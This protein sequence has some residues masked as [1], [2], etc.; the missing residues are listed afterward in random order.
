M[1]A[2]YSLATPD[3]PGSAASRDPYRDVVLSLLGAALV[4]MFA[5]AYGGLTLGNPALIDAA[6][7]L[8]LA[9]G[10]LACVALTQLVRA[11]P[12]AGVDAPPEMV[13]QETVRAAATDS[14]VAS[15]AAGPTDAQSSE[16]PFRAGLRDI[17]APRPS[18]V[19]AVRI[20]TAS[21]ALGAIALLLLGD[22][23]GTPALGTALVAGALC[24]VAAGL[25]AAVV[26]YL[27]GIDAAR[28]PEAEALA[29]GARV[30][31]WILTLTAVAVLAAWAGQTRAVL[32]LHFIVLSLNAA[33]CYSLI[34][35]SRDESAIVPQLSLN[36]GVLTTFGSRANALGSMLD[37]GERQLGIDLR[38]TWA[39]TVVRTGL[40]PLV[41]GLGLLGWLSTSLTVV[42]VQEQGLI[43]RLGIAVGGDPLGPGLHVHWPWPI[44]RVDRLPMNL[45][46]RLSIG[47][48]GEEAEGPE[49]VL[50]ARQHAENEFT[51][52][53]GNGRDLITVDAALQFR[54]ADARAWRYHTQN[55]ADALRA[56]AYRAV[57]RNTVNRTLTDALSENVV[58]TTARMR[59]M[60]QHDADALGLGV[61]VLGFTVAGMHPPVPVAD[62]YEAVVSAELGRVTAAVRAQAERNQLLPQAESAVL[63]G[64]N[65]ARAE[66]ATALGQAAGDA[67][68]FLAIQSEYR[69]SS[70]E[71]FFRQRL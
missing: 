55:P 39:L 5:A 65:S 63:V 58:A 30:L 32:L 1:S 45:V 71:F 56:I 23:T 31:A 24:I 25:V 47:H 11:R 8:E 60:V 51:L 2:S 48:E 64:E 17:M 28:L 46:Q 40:E 50:W 26:R 67:S 15:P 20:V 7:S 6:V 3:R 43:E 27:I 38:S 19:H 53:L 49:D 42:G 70:V 18:L 33:V 29:R 68:A 35:S 61:D 22:L 57:M 4:G 14:I 44:D 12:V 62:A 59:T 34:T 10:V 69:A 21:L 66:G 54:I 9:V 52:L 13:V 16:W 41:I 36:F 37:A